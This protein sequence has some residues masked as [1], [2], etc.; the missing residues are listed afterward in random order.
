M[1]SKE[2]SVLNDRR[3]KVEI[4][5]KIDEARFNKIK[6]EEEVRRMKLENQQKEIHIEK[7]QKK[8]DG[9]TSPID[10]LI[11]VARAWCIDN[12]KTVIGSEPAIRSLWDEDELEEIKSLII[13][14]V[15][16]L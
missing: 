8:E 12:N 6:F 1:E 10:Q 11:F 15:R 14:K 16:K 7:M 13:K 3:T 2:S 4:Y 5:S 9:W